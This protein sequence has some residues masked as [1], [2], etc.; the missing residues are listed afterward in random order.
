MRKFVSLLVAV[1]LLFGAYAITFG[2]PGTDATS[3]AAQPQSAAGG[4]PAGGPPGGGRARGATSVVTTALE[5]RPYEVT[6]YATGTAS[7]LRSADVVTETA[8]TVVETRL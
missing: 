8:G 5:Q 7:S 2:L 3:E 1:G 6:L 4:R